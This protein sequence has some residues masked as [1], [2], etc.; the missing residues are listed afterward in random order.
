MH[1][2]AAG[3]PLLGNFQRRDKI[4]LGALE[5]R[6]G[7]AQ[8]HPREQQIGRRGILDRDDRHELT[9]GRALIPRGAED[10]LRRHLVRFLERAKTLEVLIDGLDLGVE[11]VVF[12]ALFRVQRQPFIG[13]LRHNGIAFCGFRLAGRF[14]SRDLFRDRF[15]HRRVLRRDEFHHAR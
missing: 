1:R 5:E 7:L 13:R 10:G 4:A 15:R 8:H 3:I 11:G 6:R 12:L 14:K 9:R 2:L